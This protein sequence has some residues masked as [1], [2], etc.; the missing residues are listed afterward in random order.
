MDRSGCI[1]DMFFSFIVSIAA[2]LD[3]M[4]LYGVILNKRGD[5]PAEPL[6]KVLMLCS[7]I[8]HNLL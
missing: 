6:Y 3:A 4:E 2:E 7:V 8:V 5:Y 1:Q